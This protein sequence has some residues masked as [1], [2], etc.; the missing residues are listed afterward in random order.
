MTT[1]GTY[2]FSPNVGDLI[3]NAFSRIQIRPPAITQE[4]MVQC[5]MEANL[6][7]AQWAN[8]GVSLWTVD[9]VSLPLVQGTKTYAVDASTVMIM[10]LYIQ[11]GTVPAEVD[12]YITPFSRSDY[13]AISNKDQQGAP[14]T[15]W[16]DRLISPTLTFWQVPDGDGPYTAKYY[17]YRQ[18]QDAEYASG[19]T[20]E[21][22]YLFLDAW[23]AGLSHRLARH[24]AKP[25]EQ[26]RKADAMEAWQTAATQNTESVPFYITPGLSGYYR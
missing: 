5:R 15:Y 11:T 20:P 4:Q 16:F 10:D 9:L 21:V 18:I 22:P 25:L 2:A 6:L 14:N 17:R 7:Q 24:Y 19:G 12:R 13:A 8:A 1:S 3:L 23:A 26:I